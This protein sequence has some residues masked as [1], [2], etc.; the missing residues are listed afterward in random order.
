MLD[1]VNI[2]LVEHTLRFGW[3]CG[4]EERLVCGQEATHKR[5]VAVHFHRRSILVVSEV[6]DITED[7]KLKTDSD[8]RK[9]QRSG[10]TRFRSIGRE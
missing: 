9:N 10:N 6:L 2:A 1:S 3:S 8:S 5:L 4:V 7:G